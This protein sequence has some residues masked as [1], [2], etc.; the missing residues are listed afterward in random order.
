MRP[1]Q[2][3]MILRCPSSSP[4]G[5]RREKPGLEITGRRGQTREEG[6]EEYREQKFPALRSREIRHGPLSLHSRVKARRKDLNF[7]SH[8]HRDN[9]AHIHAAPWGDKRASGER[10]LEHR[11]S[12]FKGNASFAAASFRGVALIF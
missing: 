3:E 7:I 4:Q 8:L 9:A 12:P 5:T 6:E 11:K 2:G 1:L 10:V